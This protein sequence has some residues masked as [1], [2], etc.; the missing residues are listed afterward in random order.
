MEWVETPESTNL[1]RFGY[2]ESTQ[3]LQVEFKNGGQYQYFD[4]PQAVFEG[5]KSAGSKGQFLTQ[6]VKGT[7]RFARM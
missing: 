1:A 7:F 2:E 5:M 6:R 3:V 4:V